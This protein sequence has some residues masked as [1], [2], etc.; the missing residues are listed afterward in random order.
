MQTSDAMR[1]EIAKVYSIVIARLDR[2]TS[3]PETAVM[4]TIGR[5]ARCPPEPVIGL[6][7]WRHP[8]AGDD[9]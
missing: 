6:R 9:N 1:R 2:A 3:I 7:Q 4:G 5:G 8:V